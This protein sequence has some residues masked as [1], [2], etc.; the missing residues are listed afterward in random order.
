MAIGTK[1]VYNATGRGAD[2][3]KAVAYIKRA[4]E[5]LNQAKEAMD[6]ITSGGTVTSNL[7]ASSSF[8]VDA[9]DAAAFYTQVNAMRT[10]VNAITA[11][12]LANLLI[13]TV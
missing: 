8:N 4:Q 13:D 12:S 7:S 2:V 1:L 9:A 6:A 3:A 10:N 11:A 5:L